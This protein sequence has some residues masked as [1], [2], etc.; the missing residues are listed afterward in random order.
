MSFED[1]V[2]FFCFFCCRV[3]RS[4]VFLFSRHVVVGP[5]TRG[6]NDECV[7]KKIR[8]L[9]VGGGALTRGSGGWATPWTQKEFDCTMG[10]PGVDL[11]S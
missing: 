9:F 8:M 10:L 11:L 5:L 1:F 3:E 2:V 6:T 7:A 4:K